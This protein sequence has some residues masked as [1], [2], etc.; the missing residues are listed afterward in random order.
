MGSVR[1]VEKPPA[2]T[3]NTGASTTYYIGPMAYTAHVLKVLI[4][5]PTDTG[6]ARD[7][8]QDVL[9]AWNGRRSE[10]ERVILLPRRWETDSIP[11]TGGDGQD[12]I[13][14]QLVDTSDIVIGIFNA[15]LGGVTPRAISGTV[16]EIERADQAGKPVHIY[17]SDELVPRSARE[18]SAKLDEYREKLQK[19]ALYGTYNDLHELRSKVDR[20]IE[21]DLTALN[22][23][24]ASLS[25]RPEPAGAKP[26]ASHSQTGFA[27][28]I[29][30]RNLGDEAAEAFALELIGQGGS[31]P[32][33][34]NPHILPTI[35]PTGEF[36]WDLDWSRAN[37]G[38]V[39]VEME[40]LEN[41]ETKGSKQSISLPID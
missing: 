10:R 8:V 32:V 9:F 16:E 21:D 28:K 38:N 4:A 20:A 40:W 26:V 34:K 15:K 11:K 12:I 37:T 18:T 29:R 35:T 1:H 24:A 31:A 17:F 25:A 5:S 36:T 19:K 30:V 33:F 23:S 14:K 7:A 41:G 2:N 3:G 13:N 27:K 6:E 22:L 39:L